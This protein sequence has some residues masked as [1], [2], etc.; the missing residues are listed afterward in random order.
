MDR[1]RI[2]IA[3]DHALFREALT[4]LLN[5]Q[6]DFEVVAQAAN[7][8][9]TL[10]LTQEVKPKVVLLD[11]KF[12]DRSG[13]SVLPS[14]RELSPSTRVLML[15]MH[16]EPTFL[17]AALAAGAAG[18]VVK[19]S[20]FSVLLEAIRTVRE[21]QSFIDPSLRAFEIEPASTL[22]RPPITR[23]SER[24]RQVLI[25][26][27]QGL[28]YQT[29]ADQ[30]GISVKTVETYRGRLTTKLGFQDKADMIRFA[31]ESGIMGGSS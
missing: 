22:E 25:G 26:L 30:M 29:I 16:D 10:R 21:G 24:E 20:P 9:E 1:S 17:R 14:M 4:P 15:T 28:R 2:L 23:L 31:I 12:P 5:A 6:A 13:I 3:D 19:S 18:Y 27:A 8:E 11:I 7:A